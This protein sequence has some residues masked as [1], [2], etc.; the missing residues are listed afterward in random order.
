MNWDVEYTDTFGDWWSDL[1]E[2]EQESVAASVQ[3]LEEYGPYLRH[4]HSSQ[5]NGSGYGNMREL[6]I[7]H[8]GRP[9]R[10]LYA[11]DPARVAILLM[12]GDKTGDGRWYDRNIPRA[13]ALYRE[14]LAQLKQE[15]A[16][17]GQEVC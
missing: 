10:V 14:H 2:S 17:H 5:V 9:L 13:D 4:P 16:D 1:S 11:F 8:D 3:L 15:E 12:G 6:R 7:Q